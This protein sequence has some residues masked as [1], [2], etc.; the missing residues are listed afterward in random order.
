MSTRSNI[1]LKVRKE[2]IGKRFTFR[3]K[4]LGVK[5][6]NWGEHETIMVKNPH[7]TTIKKEYLTI[8]CHWDGYPSGVGAALLNGFDTYEKVL[9]LVLGGSCSSI[10][11]GRVR[12]YHNRKGEEWKYIKPRQSDNDETNDVW[13]E[14]IYKFEDGKW[15]VKKTYGESRDK[16]YELTKN[17][18]LN[19]LK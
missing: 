18:R 11:E 14:Y 13:I 19:M 3:K 9:A 7:K 1:I 6:D 8:Y 2:D 17:A 5:V 10:E 4:D 12:F 16:W 15:Y